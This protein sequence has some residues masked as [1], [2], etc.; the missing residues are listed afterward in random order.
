MTELC[1]IDM[2]VVCV[3]VCVHFFQEQVFVGLHAHGVLI[4]TAHLIQKQ[5]QRIII[6]HRVLHQTVP[7]DRHL[8]Q[9]QP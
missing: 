2:R 9:P 8:L 6:T 3:C 4:F 5:V 1:G 7:Q